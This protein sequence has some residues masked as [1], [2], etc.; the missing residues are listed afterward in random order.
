MSKL[1]V[2]VAQNGAR[3]NYAVPAVLAQADMLEA[4]YT[5]VSGNVG[6]GRWISVA[7]HL[8][9]V[10]RP[11]HRLYQR[12]IPSKVYERT[13]AFSYSTLADTVLQELFGTSRN[14]R[15]TGQQMLRHGLGNAN[16]VYSFL[17]WGRP[18]LK[19][20]KSRDSDRHRFLR[21]ALHRTNLPRR[22]PSV[23]GM[24]VENGKL[25][26]RKPRRR[27]ARPLPRFRLSHRRR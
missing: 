14:Y 7:R 25:N 1:R 16:L 3:R 9:V 8:P 21:K 17:G 12:Q 20:A 23:S 22:I 5:D 11:F 24:G 26:L 10:G 18:L 13:T 19:E 4:F 6:A 15:Y 27:R 2:L